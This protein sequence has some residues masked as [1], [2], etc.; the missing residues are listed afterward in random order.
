MGRN[1]RCHYSVKAKI[2]KPKGSLN[3]KTI[4][5]MQQ[6]AKPKDNHQSAPPSEITASC[7]TTT[8]A[9]NNTLLSPPSGEPIATDVILLP[10]NNHD[11]S[12]TISSESLTLEIS[13]SESLIYPE[14]DLAG[15]ENWHSMEAPTSIE[16]VSELPSIEENEH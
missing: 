3:K 2:G 11:I 1:L 12:E 7:S 8:C 6:M 4:E 16:K 5:R 9:A 15:M 10:H 13:Q 14:D